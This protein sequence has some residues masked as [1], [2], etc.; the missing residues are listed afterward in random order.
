VS[1]LAFDIETGPQPESRLRELHKPGGPIPPFDPAKVRYGRIVDPEKRT[2]KLAEC[3]AKYKE[4]VEAAGQEEQKRWREFC[5]NAALHATTGRVVA[6]GYLRKGPDGDAET[7]IEGVDAE[8]SEEEVLRRFWA[9]VQKCIAK[10]VPM[11]GHN[12]LGF[13]LPFLRQRSWMLGVQ[14]IDGILERDRYWSK[15]FIDTLARWRSGVWG[16]DQGPVSSK[17]GS[18]GE[19]FG[20]GRKMGSGADFCRL[21]EGTIEE[22]VKA[23]QYLTNDLRL[24]VGLASK[25]GVC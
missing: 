18:L 19:L 5:G 21:W 13:D 10:N 24:T 22:H 7:W 25:L 17:L 3:E 4:E 9:G 1:F 15:I 2:A 14:P 12:I 16:Q 20:L 8:T 6:I 23:V 11:V